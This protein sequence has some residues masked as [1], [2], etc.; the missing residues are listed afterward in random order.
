MKA[1]ILGYENGYLVN[2]IFQSNCPMNALIEYTPVKVRVSVE[3]SKVVRDYKERDAKKY[4]RLI[5]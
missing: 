5:E 4:I 2:G 1:T 3:G